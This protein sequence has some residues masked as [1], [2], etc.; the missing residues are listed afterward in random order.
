GVRVDGAD[1][2]DLKYVSLDDP[3]AGQQDDVRIRCPKNPLALRG[4]VIRRGINWDSVL[5]A[6]RAY[7]PQLLLGTAVQDARQMV[8]EDDSGHFPQCR[9]HAVLP[10]HAQKPLP[11]L[12]D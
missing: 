3:G 5:P 2:R 10:V 11:T 12:S 8:L 4:I 9:H 1:T 6:Y 7:R